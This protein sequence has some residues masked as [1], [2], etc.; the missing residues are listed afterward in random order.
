[1][2]KETIEIDL[3]T[4]TPVKEEKVKDKIKNTSVLNNSEVKTE[5]QLAKPKSEPKSGSV[6]GDLPPLTVQSN[7]K[8]FDMTDI[9]AIIE[10]WP[11]KLKR[12]EE[13]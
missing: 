11:G 7:E 4:F 5:D 8:K 1:M 6:L 10:E 2:P 12:K 9:K 13:V 3:L